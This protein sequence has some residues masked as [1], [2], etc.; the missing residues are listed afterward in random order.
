MDRNKTSFIL[1][2]VF[3]F[4]LS[5]SILHFNVIKYNLNGGEEYRVDNLYFY[6]LCLIFLWSTCFLLIKISNKIFLNIELKNTVGINRITKIN[7]AVTIL[8]Y[9]FGLI[10]YLIALEIKFTFYNIAIIIFIMLIAYSLRP[11][12]MKLSKK[13]FL[14]KARS[15]KTGDWISLINKEGSKVFTGK[16]YNQDNKSIQLKTE[17]NTLLVLNNSLLNQFIIENY[18]GIGKEVLFN[19]FFSLPTAVD[20]KRGKRILTAAVQNGLFAIFNDANNSVS[21]IINKVS[22]R[23]IEY[24]ISF[25]IIPWEKYSPEQV[26]D[27]IYCKILS[28]LE[29]TGVV[30][31]AH[32]NYFD[33]LKKI[34]L[35]RYLDDT[36]LEFLLDKAIKKEF[37]S[38]SIIINQGDSANTMFVLIEGL[39]KVN[40]QHPDAKAIDVGIISPGEF[41][42]EMSLFTG[43]KRTATV[44][45]LTDAVTIEIT[46][47]SVKELLTRRPELM[48]D[49]AET[50]AER[51]SVNLKAFDD[52]LNKKETFIQKF[53]AKIKAF[54]EI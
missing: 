34:E 24:K 33:V 36:D 11:L 8:I 6:M 42:G 1:F 17:N 48:N 29:I 5:F 3:L 19:I 53:I 47:D 38:Q 9:T 39:L 10:A 37:T 23:S 12:L 26:K 2:V 51:Q 16:I 13:E 32:S 54:F 20:F 41:F 44:K 4:L 7:D 50:I 49:I 45:A 35:F 31:T 14:L 27:S 21:V 43:E 18:K 52:Y 28:H 46:K 40:I 30:Q 22:E 15:S 25:T